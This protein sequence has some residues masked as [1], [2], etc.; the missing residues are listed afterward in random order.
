MRGWKASGGCGAALRSVPWR[1]LAA[2]AASAVRITCLRLK[3]CWAVWLGKASWV[4][5][6]EGAPRLER[7]DC[8]SAAAESA[9]G[10]S[11]D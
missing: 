3:S 10:E 1:A 5:A 11:P 2:K 7:G 4:E 9:P 8:N 6:L